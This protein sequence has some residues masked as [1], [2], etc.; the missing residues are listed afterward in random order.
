MSS[1][2]FLGLPRVL[3][4]LIFDYLPTKEAKKICSICN[5]FNVNFWANRTIVNI[6][7]NKETVKTVPYQFTFVRKINI[8]RS[9][10][11]TH[12]RF[13]QWLETWSVYKKLNALSINKIG[14]GDLKT[15]EVKAPNLIKLNINIE[16]LFNYNRKYPFQ[17]ISEKFAHQLR[18]FSLCGLEAIH[19]KEELEMLNHKLKNCHTLTFSGRSPVIF[20]PLVNGMTQVKSLTLID[21]DHRTITSAAQEMPNL[22]EL[23]IVRRKNKLLG[24]APIVQL[25]QLTKLRCLTLSGFPDLSDLILDSIFESNPKLQKVFMHGCSNLTNSTIYSLVR[26]S[27]NIKEISFKDC[28]LLS[29]D[30]FKSLATVCLVRMNF[31]ICINLSNIGII[32]FC[33]AWKAKNPYLKYVDF[34]NVPN[35]TDTGL[36][37]LK[38]TCTNLIN[39]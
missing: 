36:N 31:P 27:P 2:V 32:T 21:P 37:M 10:A 4:Q 19:K 18:S 15:I 6:Y 26:H 34:S 12:I 16:S 7:V 8:K 1:K 39:V 11:L 5:F 22:Q 25:D 23:S 13:F 29:D 33:R 28:Y 38:H 17:F 24:S 20:S 30:I 14:P 3:W 35:I 9:P